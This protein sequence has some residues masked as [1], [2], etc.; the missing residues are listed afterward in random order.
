VAR[1]LRSR[2][3]SSDVVARLGGDEFA[4]LLSAVGVD[5]ARAAAEDLVAEIRNSPATYGGRPFRISASIGVTAFESDDATAGEVLVNADLAMYAAKTAGRDRV[6]VYTAPEARKARAIAKLTWS[7]R[8]QDA[9]DRDRFV[10]H[11]QPILEL[12]TGQIKHGELLLR[13]KGERGKLIA[14]GAFLP[15]A[16]RYG[17]VREIDRLVVSRVAALL[18]ADG[19]SHAG[20]GRGSH[21]AA[22][23]APATLPGIALNLSAL[24]VTDHGMLAH[25]E[26]ELA[27]HRVDPR[28][29]V[30]EITETAAIS[31]M[32]RARAFCEG[33]EALGCAIALDDFGVGFGSFYY[34][35]RLPFSYL[36]I[37]G[38]FVRDLPA[39]RNDRLVVRAIVDVARGMGR[40][41]IAEFVG[42]AP[43]LELLGVLG[44]DH[45]Q[46]FHIGRPAPLLAAQLGATAA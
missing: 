6:V 28:R 24:S 3:R 29:L 9:L 39:S 16:E 14:P 22:D 46:G 31:D 12:A 44:V 11:L 1:V 13:M 41:T 45:A 33:A 37:D 10:L 21:A 40:E 15:A 23:R 5:D 30:I 32:R 7:Q 36:K 38:D 27:H 42:D 2:F 34:A 8:I 35:K 17:L 43:T 4:V 25:I 18:G 20:A 26:R 19:G